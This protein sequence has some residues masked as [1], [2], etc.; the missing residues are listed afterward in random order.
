MSRDASQHPDA[1]GFLNY[2]EVLQ[3]GD[4]IKI[5]NYTCIHKQSAVGCD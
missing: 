3:A 4:D 1:H 5:A 2:S